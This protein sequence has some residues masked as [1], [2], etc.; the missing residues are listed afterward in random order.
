MHESEERYRGK[1]TKILHRW[2]ENLIRTERVR[3]RQLSYEED[4]LLEQISDLLSPGNLMES[5]MQ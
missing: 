2:N 5:R 4:Q 3:F 1:G